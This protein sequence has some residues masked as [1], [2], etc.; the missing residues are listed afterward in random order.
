MKAL[1]GF[2]NI[3]RLDGYSETSQGIKKL[4]QKQ[5]YKTFDKYFADMDI[6]Q[7]RKDARVELANDLEDLMLAFFI[8]CEMQR[9]MQVSDIEYQKQYLYSRYLRI[10][11]DHIPK[12]NYLLEDD[13]IDDFVRKRT[14]D[15]VDVTNRKLDE[16]RDKNASSVSDNNK[17]NPET[18]KNGKSTRDD[19]WLS[20]DRAWVIGAE[21]A[22]SIENYEDFQEAIENGYTMKEWCDVRDDKE[23]ESHLAVGGKII[24]ISDPFMV[25]DSLMMFPKDTSFGA[26]PEEIDNC[27]CYLR[28]I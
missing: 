20:E 1:L 24:P 21:D 13:Y 6:P 12:E 3:N 9:R 26:G 16:T 22:N 8:F 10:V 11:R 18:N 4:S 2:D 23:R 5:K 7:E 19:W 27:R 17:T 25:G 14:G 15:I 28:Y